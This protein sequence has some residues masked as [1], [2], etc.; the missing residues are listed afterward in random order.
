MADLESVMS[1]FA[2]SVVSLTQGREVEGGGR[3]RKR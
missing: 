2:V 1:S 3:G